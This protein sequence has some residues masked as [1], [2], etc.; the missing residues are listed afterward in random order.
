M[1]LYHYN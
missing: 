1:I